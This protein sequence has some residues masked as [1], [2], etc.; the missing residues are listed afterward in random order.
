MRILVTGGAGFIGS[1][2]LELLQKQQEVESFVC[3]DALTYAG[4]EDNIPDSV[5][6]DKRYRFVK[7]EI[8]DEIVVKD[9]IASHRITHIA[10]LAAE[11]HVDNSIAHPGEFIYTNIGGTYNLLRVAQ[12][13]SHIQKFLHVSTDEVFGSSDFPDPPFNEN[14]PYRPN[15]PYSASK[16]SSDLLVRAWHRT[17]GFP[18]VITNCS[19]NYGIRQYPEKLIPKTITSILHRQ[20]ITVHG[21]GSNIRDWIHVTDHVRGLWAAL[22]YGRPGEQY[23]FGGSEERSNLEVVHTICDFMTD[24]LFN[25]RTLITFVE[26][27]K[28]NDQRYAV[29]ISKVRHEFKWQPVFQFD[30]CLNDVINWYT[31]QYAL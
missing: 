20:P 13:F 21:D 6:Q 8:N 12:Q 2:F 29:G 11:S 28:G 1:H 5:K 9:V 22:Q 16:A 15:S 4:T 31:K 27:R 10:H 23:C 17:Y 7:G 3:F 18:A 26:D 30:S 19:N 24:T 14:S 25:P